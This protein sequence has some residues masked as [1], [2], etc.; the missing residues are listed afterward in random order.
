MSLSV[1]DR[2]NLVISQCLDVD[3][4]EIKLTDLLVQD[5]GAESIDVLDITF[6]LEREFGIKIKRVDLF[7]DPDEKAALSTVSVEQIVNF[8]QKEISK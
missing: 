1:V 6:R 4:A 3:A 2:V 5:L 8:V 7:P